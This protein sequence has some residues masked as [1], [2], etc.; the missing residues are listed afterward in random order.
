MDNP[1][2]ELRARWGTKT[3]AELLALHAAVSSVLALRDA[4][5]EARTTAAEG[6]LPETPPMPTQRFRKGF[7][8]D[9]NFLFDHALERVR[10]M[11]PTVPAVEEAR[12]LALRR[13]TLG[14]LRAARR[15]LAAPP[16]QPPTRRRRAAR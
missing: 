1:V 4:L 9:V 10:A 8:R 3:A 13:E 14:I 2:P 7:L 11:R 6:L 16:P 15:Q 12:L 5:P